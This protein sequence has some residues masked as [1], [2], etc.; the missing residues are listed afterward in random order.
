MHPAFAELR[1]LV[2]PPDEAHN[3]I[4]DWA[5]CERELGHP[6]PDDYKEFISAY[7]SGILCALFDIPSPFSLT[8][9]G[10]VAPRE[11]WVQWAGIYDASGETPTELPYPAYPSI[12]GLL[13]WGLYGDVNVLSWY[14]GGDPSRWHVVYQHR[15]DGFFE[16]PGMG[17]AAFLV[18][19][20]NGTVPCHACTQT[21]TP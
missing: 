14:T 10:K 7:G 4:G 13:P 3:A 17:F 11:W 9:L 1:R 20:L 21:S 6:L 2:P 8:Q 19:A 16:V 12:P 18:A 5:A 15:E